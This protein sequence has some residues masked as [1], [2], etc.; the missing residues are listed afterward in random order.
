MSSRSSDSPGSEKWG[1]SIHRGKKIDIMMSPPTK[2]NSNYSKG[3]HSSS[4]LDGCSDLESSSSDG[5]ASSRSTDE[6]SNAS[7]FEEDALKSLH[8]NESQRPLA[9]N[10]AK[11]KQHRPS[12]YTT[13]S[14]SSFAKVVPAERM[15]KMPKPHESKIRTSLCYTP[16]KVQRKVELAAE[17]PLR[18]QALVSPACVRKKRVIRHNA[19]SRQAMMQRAEES[20]TNRDSVFQSMW[21]ILGDSAGTDE[22]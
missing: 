21:N 6:D 2:R 11:K 22:F 8:N 16:K 19:M 13:S 18:I 12:S 10:K 14:S 9:E 7:T 1:T 17:I 4:F 3:N 5:A 15:N 20:K